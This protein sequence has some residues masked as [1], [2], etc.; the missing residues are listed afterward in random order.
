MAS[1]FFTNSNE[2]TLFDK[3]KGISDSSIEDLN[4]DLK[5]NQGYGNIRHALALAPL[6]GYSL[7]GQLSTKGEGGIYNLIST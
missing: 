5:L 3:F 7:I 4:R 6:P 2:K 1:H